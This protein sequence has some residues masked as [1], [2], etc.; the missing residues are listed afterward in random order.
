MSLSVSEISESACLN[1]SRFKATLRQLRKVDDNIILR[2]NGTDTAS[3]EDCLALFNALQTTY[4]Q[5]RKAIDKCVGVLDR[6]LDDAAAANSSTRQTF[7]VKAQ[8][9]W[10]AN[11]R[12]VEDIVKRRSLDVLRSR[13]Q[14]DIN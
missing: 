14:F 13:C 7:S 9:D 3:H 5:R 4:L 12:A 6:K 8:R 2:L 1:L 11:E 10:V